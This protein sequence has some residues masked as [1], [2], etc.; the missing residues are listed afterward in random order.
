MTDA[1]SLSGWPPICSSAST[2]D[3]NSW[4]SG[5]A[6]NRRFDGSPVRPMVNEG[7]R[8][9]SS[10]SDTVM[11]GDSSA[12]SRSN[13]SI[14]RDLSPLSVEATSSIGLVSFSR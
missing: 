6:A 2:S 10:R 9:A 14:S 5:I 1:S 7:L 4:P 3:V 12:I 8:S 11:S 13:S